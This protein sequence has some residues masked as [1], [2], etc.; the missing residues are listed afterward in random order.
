[1]EEPATLR[2][3]P[4]PPPC[5]KKVAAQ[6]PGGG[7]YVVPFTRGVLVV[8]VGSTLAHRGEGDCELEGD[9]VRERELVVEGVPVSVPEGLGEGEGELVRDSVPVGEPEGL[10]EGVTGEADGDAVPGEGEGEAAA[11]HVSATSPS[12]PLPCAAPPLAGTAKAA[13]A[14]P[15]PT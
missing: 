8:P 3:E 4:P 1:M 9:A 7:Q 6:P 11:T 2:A 13:S 10:S 14:A 12:P 15:P 5:S